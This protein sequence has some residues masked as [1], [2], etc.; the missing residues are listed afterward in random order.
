MLLE[1]RITTF[2]ASGSPRGKH[3][4]YPESD[5]VKMPPARAYL[6]EGLTK[7]GEKVQNSPGTRLVFNR[8]VQI[9]VI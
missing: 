6:H 5:S 1:Y 8:Q 4:E 9:T 7:T 3:L 2:P